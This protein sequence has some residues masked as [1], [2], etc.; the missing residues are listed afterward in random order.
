M[1]RTGVLGGGS[2]NPFGGATSDFGAFN[3]GQSDSQKTVSAQES[4]ALQFAVVRAQHDNGQMSDAAFEAAQAAYLSTLDPNTQAGATAQYTIAMQQYT[5]DRNAL[6]QRVQTGTALPSDLVAFDRASLAGLDPGSTEYMQRQDRLMAAEGQAFQYDERA[7]LDKL[8][9]GYITNQQAQTWYMD[10]QNAYGDN[11]NVMQDISDKY[12]SLQ[13]RI[14]NEQDSAMVSAFNAG[15]LSVEGVLAYVAKVQT[16]DP[17]SQRA[18]DLANVATDAKMQA[19]EVSLSARYDLTREY[20]DLA[21]FVAGAKPPTSRTSTSK[22]TRT[23]LAADGVTWKTVTSTSG[24]VIPPTKAEQA[25]WAKQQVQIQQAKD[26]MAAIQKEVA[27]TPGGWVTTDDILRH[28]TQEQ[29]AVDPNSKLWWDYQ[30]QID[31]AKQQQMKD[32]ALASTGVKIAYPDVASEAVGGVRVGGFEQPVGAKAQIKAK[33]DKIAQYQGYIDSGTL[34]DADKAKYTAAIQTNKDAIARLSKAPVKATTST[35]KVPTAKTTTGGGGTVTHTGTQPSGTAAVRPSVAHGGGPVA[36]ASTTSPFQQITGSTVAVVRRSG[37]MAL[38]T[39][40]TVVPVN[41]DPKS[42]ETF[43]TAFINAIKSGAASFKDPTSGASYAIATDPADRLEQM[44][45]LDQTWLNAKEQAAKNAIADHGANSTQGRAASRAY[46]AAHD[47]A[48]S[49]I[50]Y[51]L[52]SASPGSV[53]KYDNATQAQLE[54]AAG[55]RK[56]ATVTGKA[57]STTGGQGAGGVNVIG[58]AVELLDVTERYVDLHVKMAQDAFDR[59]D[60]DAALLF[61]QQI[62]AEVAKVQPKL[63]QLAGASLD[64]AS[65][66][67]VPKGAANIAAD[68]KRLEQFGVELGTHL[69]AGQKVAETLLGTDAN[70]QAGILKTV[71]GNP[72]LDPSKGGYVLKDGIVR[73]MGAD[74]KVT[75]KN[76]PVVSVVN[77]VPQYKD[78]ANT[79]QVQMKIGT[80]FQPVL[81]P[82]TVGTIGTFTDASGQVHN[83]QGKIITDPRAPGG[84]WTESPFEPGVAIPGNPSTPL[85]FTIPDGAKVTVAGQT[86]VAAGISVPVGTEIYSWQANTGRVSTGAGRTGGTTGGAPAEFLMYIDPATGNAM[87]YQNVNGTAQPVSLVGPDGLPSGDAK[88]ITGA[89]WGYDASSLSADQRQVVGIHNLYPTNITGAFLGTSSPGA[90]LYALTHPKVQPLP[91]S[92]QRTTTYQTAGGAQVYRPASVGTGALAGDSVV[93]SAYNP[94]DLSKLLP[95]TKPTVTTIAKPSTSGSPIVNPAT[96]F[97]TGTTKATTAT[98]AGKAADDLVKPKTAAQLAAESKVT[99]A[100]TAA[101]KTAAAKTPAPIK[102]PPVPVSTG[103]KKNPSA[104]I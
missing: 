62:N 96:G 6:V 83:V 24:K 99:T 102:P 2:L 15:T 67:G 48:V 14:Y 12:A 69:E 27:A 89:G 87:V 98:V 54:Y 88:L 61:Q 32:A 81:A 86:G 34:S 22:T 90:D 58:R 38:T 49:N 23:Y 53:T 43:H 85:R 78:V 94:A 13:D 75:T 95:A 91:Q 41:T 16:D 70:P 93:T 80:K 45:Q 18:R 26:R 68:L 7:M 4:A 10:Q 52:D 46:T 44:R 63:T 76:V 72:I 17:G 51:V 40:A 57:I 31:G 104:T 33:Q 30:H 73:V 97:V 84:Y 42:F 39:T 65:Q 103:G 50:M 36:P 29:A 74:G 5:D 37:P 59:G 71:G 28:L 20:A 8:N 25:A 11:F 100:A 101:A 3:V 64:L 79:V 56:D 19:V 82:Y 47:M 21:A 66:Y 60:Y 92:Q 55:L 1:A 9:H 77:G 35:V